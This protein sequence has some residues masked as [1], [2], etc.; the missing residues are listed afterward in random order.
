MRDPNTF[1]GPV[2][3]AI[4]VVLMFGLAVICDALGLPR[5]EATAV[6][7]VLAGAVFGLWAG[8]SKRHK[9]QP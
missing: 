8:V 9:T 7:I 4:I 3:F 2:Q 1:P 5:R 6:G